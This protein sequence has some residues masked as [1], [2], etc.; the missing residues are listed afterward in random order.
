MILI[1]DDSIEWCKTMK[2]HLKFIVP[3]EEV[4]ECHKGLQA[5]NVYNRHHPGL[6]LMD[7]EMDDTDGFK[8]TRMLKKEFPDV[9]IVILSQYND[10]DYYEE[11]DIAGA[12]GYVTKD[13]FAPL[14]KYLLKDSNT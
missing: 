4:I 12:I 1:V 8:A 6:V 7:I 11:A 14:R 10:R 13:N 2:Q 3:N 5:V 9:I